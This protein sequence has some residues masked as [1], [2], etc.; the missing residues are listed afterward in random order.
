MKRAP[1]GAPKVYSDIVD[2]TCGLDSTFFAKNP[3]SRSY[4]RRYV[5]GEFWPVD[6]RVDRA[7]V[8]YVERVECARLLVGV[9]VIEPDVRA[10]RP[11]FDLETLNALGAARRR[12]P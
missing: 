10:R 11:L 4:V 2:F 8:E 7:L 1:R 9:R 6:S 3:L 5:P 12:L